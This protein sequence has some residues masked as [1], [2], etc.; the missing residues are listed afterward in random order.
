MSHALCGLG[1]MCRAIR[2]RPNIIAMP[3]DR[4]I[5]GTASGLSGGQCAAV[6][7]Q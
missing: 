1:A 2:G 6:V 7:S 5:G 4:C 3:D